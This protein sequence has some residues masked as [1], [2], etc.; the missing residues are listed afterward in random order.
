M[1]GEKLSPRQKMIGLMYLVLIALLA[2]QVSNSVLEKFIL[3]DQS[4]ERSIRSQN[5]KNREKL[6]CINELVRDAGNRKADL[7]IAQNALDIRTKTK[8]II[9]YISSLKEELIQKSGGKDEKTGRIYGLKDEGTVANLMINHKKAEELKEILN[10]YPKY[11]SNITGGEYQVLALDGHESD[12]FKHDPNQ[13]HKSFEELNFDKTPLSAAIATLTQFGTE[14]IYMESTALG[15]LAS[16]LGA[17]DIKFDNII[18]M[19]KPQSNIVAAGAR[20]KADLFLTASSSAVAPAMSI[21]GK[22]I[23]VEDGIGKVAFVALGG[24]Y[25]KEGLLKKMFSA[26]IKIKVPGGKDTTFI[27]KIEY[28]V[29]KPVIQVQSAAVQALYLNCGNEL[30]VQVPALGPSYNPSFKVKGGNFMLGQG[31]GLVTV[32]PKSPEVELQVYNDNNLLGTQIFKVRTIPK[33][34]IRVTSR[35]NEVN[36]KKGVPAPGPRFLELKAIADQSFQEFLPKD[37]RY[38]VAQWEVTL[39]RGSR[40]LKVKNVS[41]SEVSLSDFAALA[42][43]GDRIVIEIE[44]VERMNFKS[45]IEIVDLGTVIHNIPL[46]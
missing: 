17:G 18:P 36:E 23:P 21:D 33:P 26:A 38:R 7:N 30:N 5:A 29:A 39:A 31:K 13:K 8:K 10:S 20:Y 40:P 15:K 34:T 24:N 19:V 42:K 6:D 41:A 2:L 9:D 46:T 37:A 44:K 16:K 32:I 1:T 11:L 14:V 28:F 35:N 12:V 4:L 43:P 25:D 22:N 27:Q 3:I 45:E